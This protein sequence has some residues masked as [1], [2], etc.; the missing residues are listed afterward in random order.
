MRV[1]HSTQ[2]GQLALLSDPL[3]DAGRR[4]NQRG[5]TGPGNVL[6]GLFRKVSKEVEVAAG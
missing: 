2:S 3:A 5:G 4:C 6:Q 1:R